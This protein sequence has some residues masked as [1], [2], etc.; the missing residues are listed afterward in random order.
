MRRG[1][2]L[3]D[4]AV[5]TSRGRRAAPNPG[6]LGD[7]HEFAL[8]SGCVDAS[9]CENALVVLHGDL[10]SPKN[11]LRLALAL[12]LPSTVALALAGPIDASWASEERGAVMRRWFASREE[13][14]TEGERREQLRASSSRVRDA[15]LKLRDEFGWDLNRVHLLGFSD[16]G[17]VAL[18][19]AARMTG[20]ERLGSC[21]AS[22][23]ALLTE[24]ATYDACDEAPTPVMLLAGSKDDVVPVEAVRR[25]AEALRR[26]NPACGAEVKV[27]DKSHR[28]VASEPETRALMEFWSERLHARRAKASDYGD[29]VVDLSGDSH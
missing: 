18:D 3:G 22:C 24:D 23:A 25:A 12:N 14:T 7:A 10:D 29:D 4:A 13:G 15:L 5:T 8:P 9:A 2:L 27:F 20:R 19:V 17:T 11:F 6:S 16:G 1:F 26:R 21:V 28:A